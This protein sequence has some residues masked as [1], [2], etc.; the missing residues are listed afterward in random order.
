L[1]AEIK[2]I[3]L[4]PKSEF[5]SDNNNRRWIIDA[6]PTTI[7]MTAKIQPGEPKD[8]EDG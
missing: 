4:I 6:K 5:Y 8:H 1:V 7:V 2:E 3:E